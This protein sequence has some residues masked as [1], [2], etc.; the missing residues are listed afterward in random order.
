MTEPPV[1]IAIPVYNRADRLR[2]TLDSVA[3]QT[4]R[5]LRVILVDNNSTDTSLQVMQE[6]A[7][8]VDGP[9]FRVD[10]VTEPVA[11]ASNARNAALRITDTQWV[12]FFDSD[13]IMTAT[14]V[15]RAVETLRHN[16]DADIIG[17]DVRMHGLGPRPVKK[18]F[19]T[20]DPLYYGIQLGT[21]ATLRY[22]CRTDLM[23]QAGGWNPTMR[24]WDDIELGTRLLT[25][26]DYIEIVK[27]PGE[28][29]VDIMC[30]GDSITGADFTHH[31]DDLCRACR[32]M[33]DN[34]PAQRRYI[35]LL[36]LAILAALVSRESRGADKRALDIMTGVKEAADSTY[37][38]M[39]LRAAYKYTRAGGRG[40][41]RLLHRLFRP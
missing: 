7:R 26:R 10:I 33:Y 31:L 35:A 14:H 4:Y 39:L 1:T 30:H 13:D 34:L 11:G 8:E 19:D 15:E 12:M 38:R 28:P 2:P 5:P 6:W 29:T 22:M 41:A 17:W 32:A 3:A 20:S 37:H 24:G 27:A 36:K 18:P 23:R 25:C 21:M 9:D 16:P 40:A